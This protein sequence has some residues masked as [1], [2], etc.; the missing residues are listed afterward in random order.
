MNKARVRKPGRP[1]LYSGPTMKFRVTLP[2]DL[3][4]IVERHAKAE[5]LSGAQ[6]LRAVVLRSLGNSK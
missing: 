6:Y 2:R 4:N 5:G 1:R 3:G